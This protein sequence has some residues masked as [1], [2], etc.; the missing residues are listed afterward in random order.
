M[1]ESLRE[2]LRA[3]SGVVRDLPRHERGKFRRWYGIARVGPIDRFVERETRRP[4]EHGAGAIDGEGQR[5]CFMR[6]LIPSHRPAA[7]GVSAGQRLDEIFHRSF[8]VG[9]GPEVTGSDLRLAARH[10]VSPGEIAG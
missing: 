4:P 2:R 10:M 5:S 7:R 6:P 1:A 9:T 8:A 3:T